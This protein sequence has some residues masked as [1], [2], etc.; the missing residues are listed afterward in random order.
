MFYHMVDISMVPIWLRGKDLFH[1]YRYQFQ[2][3]HRIHVVSDALR[4]HMLLYIQSKR[5]ILA[6]FD[7]KDT[8]LYYTLQIL[9]L[10]ICYHLRQ[11]MFGH[12]F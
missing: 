7:C 10:E 5:S 9:A 6:L 1:K 11:G 8:F 12:G 3:H 2:Y 4:Y